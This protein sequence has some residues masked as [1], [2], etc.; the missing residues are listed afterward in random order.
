MKSRRFTSLTFVVA[1]ILMTSGYLL[2]AGEEASATT[3]YEVVFV[4][5]W[6]PDTHPQDY[7]ITHGKKGL[8]TPIIGATHGPDYSLFAAGKQP[9]PGLERLSEMGKHDPLDS[10]ITA[11]IA[12]G[13]A[14]SL[15]EFSEASE[16]PVHAPVAHR[17][18][19][20]PSYPL[21]SLVGMIAP[22]PDWFFG[23]SNV[24]LQQ[25]GRWVSSLTIEVSAWDS[26]GD[27]GI[28]YMAEDADLT[29]KK[30]TQLLDSPIFLQNGNRV[31]VGTF[32]F[33]RVPSMAT[34]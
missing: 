31:S 25:D 27:A 24:Q 18:E 29:P 8:L 33:K 23:V 1:A 12:A 5:S 3:S 34:E 9:T 15:I 26:G 11:A 22:S 30:G 10:E 20:N 14:G 13:S 4:P 7:P 2:H 32:I 16:G 19:I 28:T 6:N 17:F 21:V